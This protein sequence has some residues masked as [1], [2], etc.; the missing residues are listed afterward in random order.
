MSRRAGPPVGPVPPP[1]ARRPEE[2]GD[3]VVGQGPRHGRGTR[4]A[5]RVQTRPIEAGEDRVLGRGRGHHHLQEQAG[6]TSDQCDGGCR[7]MYGGLTLF[8]TA[9]SWA[10][11]RIETR[12]RGAKISRMSPSP[13]TT[14]ACLRPGV[15]EGLQRDRDRVVQLLSGRARPSFD[16]KPSGKGGD[17]AGH[18][19]DIKCCIR[20]VGREAPLQP[21]SPRF[22]MI[23][24]LCPERVRNVR[25][26]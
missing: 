3:V 25:R 21:E 19:L 4:P 10:P 13:M 11:S 15:G 17:E 7:G 12:P 5:G 14:C 20:G 6:S 23:G 1:V 18:R 22:P 8:A 26:R 2:H 16:R 9:A 24:Q